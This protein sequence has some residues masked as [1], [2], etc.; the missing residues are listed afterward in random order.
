VNVASAA[1]TAM[2][3]TPAAATRAGQE[4][5]DERVE[6]VH[7]LLGHIDRDLL[8]LRIGSDI[9]LHVYSF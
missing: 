4:S 2:A 8:V 5:L 3:S 7:T 9:R 6:L 1:V